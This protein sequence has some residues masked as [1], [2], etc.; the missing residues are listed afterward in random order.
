MT[1]H[2]P[3]S[4][5]TSKSRQHQER[6]GIQSTKPPKSYYDYI[7]V[8]KVNI[9]RLNKN[10]PQGKSFRQALEDDIFMMFSQLQMIRI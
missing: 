1:N 8:I 7:K 6:Q 4:L 3:P 9:H 10:L 5:A 2:L